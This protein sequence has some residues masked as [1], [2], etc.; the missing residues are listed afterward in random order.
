MRVKYKDEI[1]EVES[2][3]VVRDLFKEEIEQA[4]P[5]VVAC[6]FNNEVMSLNYKI[7]RDGE[8]ELIDIGTKDGMRVYRRGLIYIVAKAVSEVYPKA[9]FAINYQLYHALLCEIS[10][11][12]ITEELIQK[13][14]NRVQEIIASNLPIVR[15]TMT[16][17]EAVEFYKKNDTLKGRLQLGPKDKDEIVLYYCE[18]YYNYFYGVLPISTGVIKNYD[19]SKYDRGFLVRFPSRKS[20]AILT[21]FKENPKLL[22]ALEEYEDVHK[23]L[24]IDTLYKLNRAVKEGTIREYILLDEALHDK[25]ISGIADNI[26]KN[27]DIKV[28]LI[29]GPSSS[30][31]T[32]FARRLSLELRLNGIKPVT[33]SVDNYFVE[34]G[35]TPKDE[36]GQLD[37]ECIEALDRNLLN[38]DI[39]KLLSGEEIQAPTFNFTKGAK[40]YKGNTMK[41][42]KNQVL[43]MEGIHCLNDE[44]TYLIPKEHKYKI[45][46]SCLTVLNMDYYNRISTTDSRLVRRIVRDKQFRNYSALDTLERWPSVNRGESKNIFPFQ[47]QADIMFNS[48]LIYELGVLKR[49]AMPL[50]AEIGSDHR[51]YSEARRLIAMLSYFEDIP[52][53]YIPY[54]SLLREFIGGSVFQ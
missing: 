19:I 34:R 10:N 40:E 51:E 3:T 4:K 14:N 18:D 48:S 13:I 41:L 31:K 53:K 42:D 7:K 32:T 52:V 20:P 17:K 28:V 23:V 27:K 36:N 9:S 33:M 12:E 22:E 44:L 26:A 50:L 5:A 25:K 37:Y 11:M 6:R 54:N 47:E 24:D 29:A 2:G 16:K 43:V 38:N 8:I 46:I 21:D 35:E 49:Y 1:L 15:K 39:L 30:S 45:Y